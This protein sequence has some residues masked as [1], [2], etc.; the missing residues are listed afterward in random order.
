MIATSG[1][2]YT[3]EQEYQGN[4]VRGG[5]QLVKMNVKGEVW[6]TPAHLLADFT[7]AEGRPVDAEIAGSPLSWDHSG[8]QNRW[9]GE[10]TEYGS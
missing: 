8:V 10:W 3:T 4:T 2:V 1:Y 9:S 6:E 5:E 7:A